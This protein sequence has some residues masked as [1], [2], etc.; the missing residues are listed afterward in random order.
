MAAED[1]I[2]EAL[3]SVERAGRYLKL[4]AGD[5]Q[6]DDL[7][8]DVINAATARCESETG[9]K[10]AARDHTAMRPAGDPK[11]S[12]WLILPQRPINSI[13]EIRSY[14]A[15]LSAS[16]IVSASSY[17]IY[18][19]RGMVLL[20]GSAFQWQGG[21][22]EAHRVQVDAN[23]GWGYNAAPSNPLP[24]PFAKFDRE[25]VPQ[26]LAMACLQILA[27][28]Y[29]RADGSVHISQSRSAAG[30][31]ATTTFKDEPIPPAAKRILAQY[32]RRA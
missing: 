2:N 8:S 29:M 25:L 1:L 10:L 26:D 31:G 18:S 17:T 30:V 4:D 11:G 19:E 12:D 22:P 28:W 24:A 9:Y 21:W 6:T 13:S 14:S 3:V 16:S 20:H 23:I 15:D 5:E 27:D 32:R 7:L